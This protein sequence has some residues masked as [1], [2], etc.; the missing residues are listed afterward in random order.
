MEYAIVYDSV[1]ATIADS[2]R[3]NLMSGSLTFFELNFRRACS[4]FLKLRRSLCSSLFETFLIFYRERREN[5]K[6]NVKS[7]SYSFVFRV[8][9]CISSII[10]LIGSLKQISSQK[11]H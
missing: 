11:T 8:F 1:M 9:Q 7:N 3:A 5:A 6:I 4:N 10:F 2:S